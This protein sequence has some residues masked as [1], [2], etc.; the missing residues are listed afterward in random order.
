M[1]RFCISLAALPLLSLPALA[2]GA[3]SGCVGEAPSYAEV[4]PPQRGARQQGPIVVMPDGLCAD[5]GGG[6][7]TRIDSLTVVIDPRGPGQEGPRTDFGRPTPARR[8]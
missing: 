6:A 2:D 5:L 4:A 3:G 7:N 8:Y 1:T